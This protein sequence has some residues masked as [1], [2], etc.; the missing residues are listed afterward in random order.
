MRIEVLADEQQLARRAADLVCNLARERPDATLG[1]A[2]GSTPLGLYGELARR[3]REGRADLS[4]ITA[5][6]IDELYGVASG[7]PAT[8]ASY[9][10]QRLTSQVRLRGFHVMESEAADPEAECARFLDLIEKAGGLNLVVLGIGRN[11]HIAFNEPGSPFDSRARRVAL[12]PETRA[13]YAPA[14]GSLGAT[15]AEALTLGI[16][17]LLVARRVL[18]L[19]TGDDKAPA[20]AAAFEGPPT[21]ALP[22]SA[23]QRHADLTV[24]LDR[25]AASRLRRQ[26][27]A[28]LEG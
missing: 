4:G 25:A 21:E 2:S 19:A 7:H 28:A 9:F 15:P 3:A 17:D 13:A 10:R 20:V 5:F 6:A 1:L 12:A 27:G 16:S 22:A 18:Q 14:F 23:L 11:G 8:N 26:E 24:L